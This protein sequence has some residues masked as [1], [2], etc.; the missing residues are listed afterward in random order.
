VSLITKTKL[1]L[2]AVGDHVPK[3]EVRDKYQVGKERVR[4]NK[5]VQDYGGALGGFSRVK[6]RAR[7]LSL[8]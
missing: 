1:G 5:K 3:L 8:E 6:E 4:P 7:L 2:S